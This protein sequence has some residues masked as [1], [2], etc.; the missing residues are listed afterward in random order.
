[1]RD[2]SK[3]WVLLRTFHLNERSI[4]NMFNGGLRRSTILRRISI[5]ATAHAERGQGQREKDYLDF[6]IFNSKVTA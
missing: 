3:Q 6:F 4:R 5:F 2:G 1:M